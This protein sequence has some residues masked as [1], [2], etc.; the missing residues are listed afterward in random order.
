MSPYKTAPTPLWPACQETICPYNIVQGSS[1]LH[2]LSR[3]HPLQLLR[4]SPSINPA[5]THQNYPWTQP[6]TPQ[7]LELQQH[8]NRGSCCTPELLMEDK[9]ARKQN[10]ASKRIKKTP[11]SQRLIPKIPVKYI[12]VFSLKCFTLHCLHQTVHVYL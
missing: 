10:K 12:E 1:S 5:V 3:K 11:K 4:E 8:R 9:K 7:P 6:Q 2:H